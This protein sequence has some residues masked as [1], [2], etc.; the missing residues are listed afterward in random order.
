[1]SP[2]Y[3]AVLAVMTFLLS[4]CSKEAAIALDEK[5]SYVLID[6]KHE[7]LTIYAM[8]RNEDSQPI[9]NLYVDFSI[10]HKQLADQLG[11]EQV[12]FDQNRRG[13]PSRFAVKAKSGFFISESFPLKNY[14]RLG[15]LENA[16]FINV[17]QRDEKVLESPLNNIIRN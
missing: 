9:H 7:F 1:M 13:V 14:E 6:K 17:Y 2:K 16:V 3:M 12:L 15:S 10:R 11:F 5:D 4:G 8:V